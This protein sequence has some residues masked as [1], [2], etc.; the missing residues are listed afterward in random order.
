M[1]NAHRDRASPAI[2][3][4]T[5]VIHAKDDPWIPSKEFREVPWG[6]LKTCAC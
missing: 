1:R 4:P 3:T 2:R 6:Q 5:L